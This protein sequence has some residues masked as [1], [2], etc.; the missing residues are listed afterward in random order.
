MRKVTLQMIADQVGVSKALVSKAL[1]NDPAV[2]NGTR[3]EIWKTA[4]EMGYSFD[5]LRKSSV[6]AKT[7][8]IAVLMPEAYLSDIEYWGKIIRGID[9]ELQSHDFS[10]ILSGVDIS[11]DPQ[12]GLPSSINEQKVDGALL[13]GHMPESYVKALDAKGMSCVLVDSNIQNGK[14]DHILANNYLGAC[15][16]TNRLLQAG[17]RSLAFVGDMETAWSFRERDRGFEDTVREHNKGSL[18]QVSVTWVR[19][20]GVS[21]RGNYTNAEFVEKLR[22]AITEE[23][24]TGFFCANDMLAIEVLRQL[25]NWGYRCPEQ[26][27]VIGF[28][29]LSLAEFMIPKLTTV[30]VPKEDIGSR[31]VRAVLDRIKHPDTVSEL[32]QLE[33]ELIERDTVMSP[34]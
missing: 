31:A 30:R 18:E 12:E 6:Y 7:G 4:H 32:I 27:S 19:G 9:R 24:V 1:S 16:A 5:K 11:V 21:G 28:D 15:E 23:K 29:D 33:T 20:L 14:H 17:H 26:A 3:E 13:L 8:N 25:S 2:N 22:L 34:Q 10:M